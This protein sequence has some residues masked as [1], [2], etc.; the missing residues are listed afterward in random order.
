LIWTKGVREYCAEED[1][2]V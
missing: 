1:I 2:W